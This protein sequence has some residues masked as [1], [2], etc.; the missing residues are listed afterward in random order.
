MVNIDNING[1]LK[2][3]ACLNA[4]PNHYCNF[5]V[6][7]LDHKDY[8]MDTLAHYFQSIADGHGK[9]FDAQLWHIKPKQITVNEIIQQIDTWFFQQYYSPTVHKEN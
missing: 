3:M 8:F 1:Y 6:K 4:E 2:A 9:I 5:T 7:L